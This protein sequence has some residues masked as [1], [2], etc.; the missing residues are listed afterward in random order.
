[1]KARNPILDELQTVREQLLVDAGGT[2]DALVDRLQ[3]DQ[4]VSGRA[5]WHRPRPAAANE[6]ATAAQ[7]GLVVEP[8]PPGEPN[9][10]AQG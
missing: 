1:M 3:A 8:S 9:A 7:P 10:S 6:S 4:R 2:L 5:A